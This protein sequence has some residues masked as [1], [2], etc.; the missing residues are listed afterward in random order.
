MIGGAAF[1]QNE[2]LSRDVYQ[3]NPTTLPFFMLQLRKTPT[4]TQLTVQ[5]QLGP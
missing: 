4:P 2:S 5:R 3:S 1:F